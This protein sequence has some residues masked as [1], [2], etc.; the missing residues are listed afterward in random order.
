MT[1]TWLIAVSALFGLGLLG[2]V[3]YLLRVD[4]LRR[5]AE[6]HYRGLFENSFDAVF[7]LDRLDQVV[8][9]NPRAVALAG[10]TRAALLTWNLTQLR[11]LLGDYG[12]QVDLSA[13]DREGVV[14]SAVTFPAANGSPRTLEICATRTPGGGCQ[15]ALREITEARQYEQTLRN[16]AETLQ[17]II[18]A[19]PAEIAVVDQG[20]IIRQ[21]NHAWHGAF[22]GVGAGVGLPYSEVRAAD[23]DAAVGEGL[24]S[25]LAGRVS[26]FDQEYAITRRTG[27]R[28]YRL[29]VAPLPDGAVVMHVE[30][31]DQHF[32]AAL[33]EKT[34]ETLQAIIDGSPLPILALS[35][36]GHVTSWNA[37]AASLFGWAADEM[38]SRRVPWGW[39]LPA[40]ERS[41]DTVRTKSGGQVEVRSWTRAL[42]GGY[43]RICEDL[44][45]TKRL[46]RQLQQSQKMEAVGQLAGGVA[47]EFS[48]LLTVILGFGHVLMS[49]MEEGST[50][51][52]NAREVVRAAE[53]GAGLTRQLLALGRRQVVEPRDLALNESARNVE[54]MLERVLGEQIHWRSE[55]D[56]AA[57]HIFADPG[58]VEQVI[59]NLALNAKD[60]MPSGGALTLRTSG[61][62]PLP[63]GRAPGD[64]VRLT[65]LD[66]G[67]GMSEE[68]KAQI[69][70][71]FFT[72]KAPGQGTGLGLAVVYGI[73][74]KCGGEIVV[75]SQ[76]GE[77]TRF[78][79]YFPAVRPT[80]AERPRAAA[81]VGRRGSE[82]ILVLEDEAGVRELLRDSLERRGYR[83]LTA[84]TFA[85]ARTLFDKHGR[86]TSLLLTDVIV[87]Q[88]NVGE[89]AREFERRQPGLRVVY[90]SG[91]PESVLEQQRITG[92]FL[93]K[94]FTPGEL[95]DRLRS[96]LDGGR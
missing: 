77:G 46:E 53:R 82:M 2:G 32:T 16:K 14:R 87:P 63:S 84:A 22:H 55:L 64:F 9:A 1:S 49:E 57:P 73:V 56:E 39:P 51:Q 76:V 72:T 23:D 90:M 18:D 78:D 38:L 44:T 17:A 96:V 25:V 61:P 28:W 21:V 43:V 24:A 4:W 42:H 92:A 62:H 3:A 94:P 69:F 91:Y 45:E 95:A 19:V 27:I 81:G 36:E 85:E 11:G 74:K 26:Q 71:P 68:V 67:Q 60:A 80:L 34:N 65:V 88:G 41:E 30:T 83:V 89:M 15:L 79:V 37:A 13:L 35:R 7:V 29:L 6:S 10:Q 40:S 48:N 31:T 75:Q 58:Q 5:R 59:L 86:E 66:E 70:D 20:G 8:D 12:S 47:H 33:L 50:H 93:P 54:R 52:G